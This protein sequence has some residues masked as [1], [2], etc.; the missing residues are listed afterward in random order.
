MRVIHGMS[1]SVTFS[2]SSSGICSC[3]SD[4][5]CTHEIRLGIERKTFHKSSFGFQ[6]CPE[7]FLNCKPSPSQFTEKPSIIV[8]A[9]IS[10]QKES[11][12]IHIAFVNSSCCF[13]STI[14]CLS[15]KALKTI[16]NIG[17]KFSCQSN[18]LLCRFQNS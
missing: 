3:S 5:S 12:I 18:S 8:S 9:R 10:P 7:S 6:D 4:S 17:C 11:E 2:H 16:L 14:S 13:I 15:V 1:A